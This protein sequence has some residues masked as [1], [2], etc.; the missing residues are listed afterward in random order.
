[1][2]KLNFKTAFGIFFSFGKKTHAFKMP[3][4]ICRQNHFCAFQ[5]FPKKLLIIGNSLK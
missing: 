5:Y 2:I 3:Q 1:M 4:K